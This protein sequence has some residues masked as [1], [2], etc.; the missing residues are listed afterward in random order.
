[1]PFSGRHGAAAALLLVLAAC[2]KPTPAP[3]T[4]LLSP[5]ACTVKTAAVM[6]F[7]KIDDGLA[8]KCLRVRGLAAESL[9]YENGAAHAQWKGPA[10]HPPRLALFWQAGAPAALKTH[11]QF[12]EVTGR[13]FSCLAEKSRRCAI[14]APLGLDVTDTRIIPTAMD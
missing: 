12:V 8:G 3:P 5:P 6:A 2:A 13:L 7:N 4:A 11:P 10:D 1:M 14:G 9:L